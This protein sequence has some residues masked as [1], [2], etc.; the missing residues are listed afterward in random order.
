MGLKKTY[1]FIASVSVALMIIYSCDKKVGIIP[2]YE[3]VIPGPPDPSCVTSYS[4]DIKP[5]LITDCMGCHSPSFHDFS[6]Y[7]G[8]KTD[9][10]N[11]LLELHVL[12]LKDMP[13]GGPLSQTDRDKIQCWIDKGAPNN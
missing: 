9:V 4:I 10:D 5:L 8:T 13:V 11:G 6:T 1:Y 7:A 12:K 3:E 2:K